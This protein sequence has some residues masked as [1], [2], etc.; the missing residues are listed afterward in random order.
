MCRGHRRFCDM[1]VAD[2]GRV[3]E[4]FVREIH[5]VVDEQP[6]VAFRE[7]RLA[8][9][10]PF[11]IVVPMHVRNQRKSASAGSPGQTQTKRYALR[12]DKSAPAPADSTCP[13][14]ACACIG[15]CRRTPGRD[16]GTRPRRPPASPSKAAAAGASMRLRA[17]RSCCLTY[18]RTPS[19][20]CRPCAPRGS[21]LPTSWLHA[22]AY[23]ALRG[24]IR[25]V[26]I[27]GLLASVTGLR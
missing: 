12:Q 20:C 13:A 11:G 14:R 18:A 9:A 3:N 4:G 2:A 16:S 15:L 6:I 19:A 7:H 1:L 23:Q 22:A 17:R 27:E 5:Q 25:V 8:V 24:K 10:C 26:S 21:R